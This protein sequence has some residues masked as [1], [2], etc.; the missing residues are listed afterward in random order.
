MIKNKIAKAIDP[1]IRVVLI[2]E[3][4]LS[5][6]GIQAI[7]ADKEDFE[8]SGEAGTPADAVSL[9][10]RE[11]PDVILMNIG[12]NGGSLDAVPD[13]LAVSEDSRLLILMTTQNAEIQHKAVCL[14]ALGVITMDKPPDIM[15]KAIQRIHAGEVWLDRSMTAS[16]LNS[17]SPAGRAKK[18]DPE[19][20]KIKSLTGRELEVIKLVGEGLKNKM[21]GERLFISEITVHHHLTAIYSKLDATDRLELIIYAFRHGLAEMPRQ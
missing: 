7:L 2:D 4:A 16:V 9:I 17:L 6:A 19:A 20:E 5:R 21:I 3:Y 14:G 8:V 1:L 18:T 15:I 10:E 11:Q 12:T 13:L